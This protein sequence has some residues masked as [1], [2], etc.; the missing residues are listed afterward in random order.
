MAA[1]HLSISHFR[2]VGRSIFV[3]NSHQQ[4]MCMN[5][6]SFRLPLNGKSSRVGSIGVTLAINAL[7]WSASVTAKPTAFAMTLT[8]TISAQ[9]SH[10]ALWG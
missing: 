5:L 10:A 6:G 7:M 9:P 8:M 3:Q 2:D 4:N 1:F